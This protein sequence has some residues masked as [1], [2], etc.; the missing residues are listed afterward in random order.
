V[1]TAYFWRVYASESE[2]V[3]K[4]KTKENGVVMQKVH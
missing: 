3:V 2:A 4:E 1:G